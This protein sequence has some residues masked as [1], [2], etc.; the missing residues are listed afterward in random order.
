MGEGAPVHDADE[1][2][3]GADTSGSTSKPI[4]EAGSSQSSAGS[5]AG[6]SLSRATGSLVSPVDALWHQEIARMRVFLVVIIVTGTFLAGVIYFIDVAQIAKQVGWIGIGF[7]VVLTTIMRIAIRDP[8]QYTGPRITALA[9]VCVAGT[10]TGVYTF[11]VFSPAVLATMCGVFFFSPTRARGGAIAVTVAAAAAYAGLALAIATGAIGDHGL[12]PSA[13][14]GVVE[15]ISIVA[16]VESFYVAALLIGRSTRRVMLEA[17]QERDK[18]TRALAQREALLLEARQELED[19]LRAG[20][21]GRYTDMELGSFRLGGIIGRGGMGD[22]YEA[23]HRETGEPAAVKLMHARAL[24]DPA[25]VRRFVREAKVV[26]T[27]DAPGVVRVHEVGGVDAPVPYIAMERLH[28]RD[29]SEILRER[30]R[31]RLRRAIALVTEVSRGLDAAHAA[32]IVHRDIKPRNLFLAE[33]SE[34]TKVW[35]ILDFGVSKL[36]DHTGTLTAGRI[37]GTPRYMAPEQAFGHDVGP[38]ADV[39]SL[40]VVAHRVLTGRP[41]FGGDSTPE[42]LYAVAHHMPPDPATGGRF[43]VDVARVLALGL[44]KKPEHRPQSAGAFA[45]ALTAAAE[46]D[47]DRGLRAHADELLRDLPWGSKG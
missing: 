2:T 26:S 28:G 40:A 10:T 13:H 29:L 24:G 32:G 18:A 1:E 9:L 16:A 35:K 19:A 41:A 7:V 33:D 34:G 6:V 39:F 25:L 20:G 14:Y 22:V 42:V 3:I 44:A 8:A 47:L 11:G 17:L 36:G 31:L 21:I 15:Q 45:H 30:P 38:Q 27:L 5:S 43:P 4:S 37:I 46:G 12:I 23:T